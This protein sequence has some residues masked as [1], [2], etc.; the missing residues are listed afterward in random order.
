MQ[1]F[2]IE[3][4]KDMA[5]YLEDESKFHNVNNIFITTKDAVNYLNVQE[6]FKVL[7]PKLEDGTKIYYVCGIHHNPDGSLGETDTTLLVSFYETNFANLENFC[8]NLDC[9]NCKHLSI[10]ECSSSMWKEKKFEKE[11]IMIS[12]KVS[13]VM[14]LHR[15]WNSITYQR[16]RF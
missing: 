1:I 6:Y 13:L 2:A 9:E 12:T 8:G 14:N 3:N 16:L 5:T 10:K 4:S 15:F 7:L 11:L